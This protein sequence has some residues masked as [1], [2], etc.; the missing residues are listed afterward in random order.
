MQQLKNI[1]GDALETIGNAYLPMLMELIKISKEVL[2]VYNPKKYINLKPFS[3]ESYKEG[4]NSLNDSIKSLLSKGSRF[5]KSSKFSLYAFKAIFK[6]EFLII[7]YI[8][9]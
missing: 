9:I 7:I 6:N 3:F 1:F 4:I 5:E 2:K 8:I